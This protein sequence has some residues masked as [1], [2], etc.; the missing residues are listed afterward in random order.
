MLR[1]RRKQIEVSGRIHTPK[2][3]VEW[4]AIAISGRASVP[5]LEMS[6]DTRWSEYKTQGWQGGLDVTYALTL[7]AGETFRSAKSTT[8]PLPA[9]CA[10]GVALD[11]AAG[12]AVEMMRVVGIVSPVPLAKLWS[13]EQMSESDDHIPELDGYFC[14][15][16][17]NTDDFWIGL[18]VPLRLMPE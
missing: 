1:R 4:T 11:V 6:T 10:E 17:L 13:D 7:V 8:D 5:D 3:C 9:V 12:G 16:Q 14:N 15:Y 2:S 18:F